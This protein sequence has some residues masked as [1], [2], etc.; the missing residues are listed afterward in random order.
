MLVKIIKK[1]GR[2]FYRR[3]SVVERAWYNLKRVA[4][5]FGFSKNWNAATFICI[6]LTVSATFTHLL[7]Q[8]ARSC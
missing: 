8:V 7:T 2:T 5:D 3:P 6:V 4:P 1:N